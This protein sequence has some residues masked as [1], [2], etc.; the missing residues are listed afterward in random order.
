M[1]F[2]LSSKNYNSLMCH[3]C[4]SAVRSKLRDQRV[5]MHAR[6]I[7]SADEAVRSRWKVPTSSRSSGIL[8]YMAKELELPLADNVCHSFFMMNFVSYNIS[9]RGLAIVLTRCFSSTSSHPARCMRGNVCV[10]LSIVEA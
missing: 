4:P 1:S 8:H 2:E 9:F 5:R 7:C 6:R 10:K 3:E